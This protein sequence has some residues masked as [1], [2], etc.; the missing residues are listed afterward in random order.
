MEIQQMRGILGHLKPTADQRNAP[1]I[2]FYQY[3]EISTG[4]WLLV[5]QLG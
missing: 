3:V 1:D 5:S 2:H 4:W